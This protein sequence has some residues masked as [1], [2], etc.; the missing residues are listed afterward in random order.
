VV[1]HLSLQFSGLVL[2]L[3]ASAMEGVIDCEG[4]IGMPLI[5]LRGVANI[6]FTALRQRKPD[7]DLV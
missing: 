5:I 6:D 7:A 1:L 4:Q 2:Q 3:S